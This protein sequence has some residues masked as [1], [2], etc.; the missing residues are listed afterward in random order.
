VY[1]P[2]SGQVLSQY[3]QIVLSVCVSLAIAIVVVPIVYSPHAS[4]SLLG[5][6]GM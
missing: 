1:L 5:D 6:A 4:T 3:S 2:Q